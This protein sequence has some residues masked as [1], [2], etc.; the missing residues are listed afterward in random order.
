MVNVVVFLTETEYLELLIFVLFFATLFPLD[1]FP[2]KS[3]AL[4]G[5]ELGLVQPE[6]KEKETV[7]IK[8]SMFSFLTFKIAS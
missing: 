7:R 1:L 3:E 4:P 8:Q 6:C 5:R 2:S